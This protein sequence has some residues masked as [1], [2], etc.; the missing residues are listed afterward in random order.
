MRS[1]RSFSIRRDTIR[2]CPSEM[3]KKISTTA[4]CCV[5]EF[6]ELFDRN[7]FLFFPTQLGPQLTRISR[8]SHAP[9]QLSRKLLEG[10]HT[11]FNYAIK[12]FLE[13]SS[14][15]LMERKNCCKCVEDFFTL[16]R[17]PPTTGNWSPSA[18]V[19]VYRSPQTPKPASRQATPT[20]KVF[21]YCINGA[22]VLSLLL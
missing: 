14:E 9:R 12:S 20:C 18:F 11:T 3:A 5:W 6:A 8:L 13:R 4:N 16:R 17:R 19:A 7:R 22:R 10:K 15:K 21:T 2:C 1:R